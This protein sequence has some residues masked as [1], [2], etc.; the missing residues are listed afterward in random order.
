MSGN[1]LILHFLKKILFYK[2]TRNFNYSTLKAIDLI[3]YK[4]LLK[5]NLYFNSNI[6]FII[7]STIDT[8]I[9]NSFN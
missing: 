6:Y 8:M 2:I 3:L 4:Y 5:F 1:A 7:S 9:M